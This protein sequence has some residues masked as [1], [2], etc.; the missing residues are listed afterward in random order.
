MR[1][2]IIAILLLMFSLPVSA[3]SFNCR[4]ARKAAEVAICQ[5]S[6]LSN[7]DDQLSSAYYSLP[8]YVRKKVRRSQ[9]R[10]LRNRNRCGSNRRCIGRAYRSRINQLSNY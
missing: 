6:Y 10:W 7:L 8:R 1:L 2:K 4:Y 3:V 9:R 5:S